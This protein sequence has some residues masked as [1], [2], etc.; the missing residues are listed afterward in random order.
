ML[1]LRKSTVRY[2]GRSTLRT[3]LNVSG[4]AIGESATEKGET[5]RSG[6]KAGATT[7]LLDATV[8]FVGIAV[9]LLEVWNWFRSSASTSGRREEATRRRPGTVHTKSPAERP[10][11]AREEERR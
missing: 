3:Y 2:A 1:A 11:L 7:K 10:L 8:D 5:V 6:L 9:A 4:N